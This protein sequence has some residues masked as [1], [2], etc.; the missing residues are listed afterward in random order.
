MSLYSK[1]KGHLY[2]LEKVYVS[3]SNWKSAKPGDYVVIYRNGDRWPKKYSS[4][5]TCLCILEEI[6][7][8]SN[9]DA[10]LKECSNKSVFSKEEL[11]KFYDDN[12][13]RNVIKLMLYKT[14]ENKINLE[15]LIDCGLVPEGNG[16]RPFVEV[17][18]CLYD[19]FLKGDGDK[20]KK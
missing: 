3:K 15:K 17:P 10:Y 13:Y 7:F 4:V 9:K 5:C 20:W 11:E 12:E 8:P 16:P 1:N 14:Y 6:K 18:E 19:M 2:S